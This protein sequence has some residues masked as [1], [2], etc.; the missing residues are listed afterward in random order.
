M[1]F[2][3]RKRP[4]SRRDALAE[5]SPGRST[6]LFG[7][8]GPDR[9]GVARRRMAPEVVTVSYAT[10]F[11]VVAVGWLAIGLV[12]SLVMGRRGH[13]AFSWLV[14]GSLFGPLGLILAVD[15]WRH[16]EGRDP[17]LVAHR[18]ASG[19]GSVDVLV[20]FDGSPE[21]KA[22]FVAA[23]DLLG[24]RV[25]RLTLVTV[26]PYDG[27]LEQE[28]LARAALE[29]EAK[30]V[31]HMPR[32]E[33]LHGRPSEALLERAA[34]DGYDLLVIG[35]RG[36]GMSRALLGSAA[37]DIARAGKIPVLLAGTDEYDIPQASAGLHTNK[38]L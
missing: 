4:V 28:R 12:L 1:R 38:S 3:P 21:S 22:A 6:A 29:R 19:P 26:V 27:G 13:D 37:A 23:V 30:S 32:L 31:G 7:T 15:A 36:A 9:D 25:G 20:G 16:G 8:F 17:E 18:R 10:L 14:L 11:L 33:I 24:S 2:S 35:T 5:G 34:E